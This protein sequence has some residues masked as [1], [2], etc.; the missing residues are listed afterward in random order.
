MR[1]IL[2]L[3]GRIFYAEVWAVA[4]WAKRHQARMPFR[5]VPVVV[6][7]RQA[8]PECKAQTVGV[9]QRHLVLRTG[10]A[11]PIS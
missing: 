6:Q 11:Q 7:R 1:S 3:S 9:G 5:Q 10:A 2:L 8:A 4:T